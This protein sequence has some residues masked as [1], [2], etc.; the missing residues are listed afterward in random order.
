MEVSKG[1]VGHTLHMKWAVAAMISDQQ[2]VHASTAILG[3]GS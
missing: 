2:R 1:E 3:G